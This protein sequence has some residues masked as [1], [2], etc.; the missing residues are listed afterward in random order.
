MLTVVRIL[1]SGGRY[2]VTGA[3][4]RR[5]QTALGHARADLGVERPPP[6][7][8]RRA[9]RPDAGA[10]PP[11]SRRRPRPGGAAFVDGDPAD[12][13]A[14]GHHVC[15][16]DRQELRVGAGRRVL[17]RG[18]EEGAEGD[19]VGAALGGLHGQVQAVVA[20]DADHARRGPRSAGPRQR[21]VVLAHMDAVA[22]ERGRRGPG[23]SL[24]ITATP[25]AW[26][27]GMSA[28]TAAAM[29]VVGRVLQPD[30]Q[31]R[32]VAGVQGVGQGAAE[33]GQ[34]VEPGRG[35]QVEA[36]ERRRHRRGV[37]SPEQRLQ[38]VGDRGGRQHRAHGQAD[39]P[40]KAL[41]QRRQ[42]ARPARAAAQ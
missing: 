4:A 18:R 31:R 32:D 22:A 15:L 25:R 30:L 8:G 14:G 37:R 41:P 28:S 23:R 29:I 19:V 38:A 1:A 2:L 34:V 42:A 24:R 7:P 3:E 12:G 9:W 10:R 6:R 5:A 11:G 17:G 40:A 21:H 16:P 26:A 13:D 33:G 35:D 27:M 39:E 20:G 36:A